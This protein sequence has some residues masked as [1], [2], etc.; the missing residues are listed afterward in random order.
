MSLIYLGGINGSG[1]TTVAQVVS[2][3][4]PNLHIVHGSRELMRQLNLSENDYKTLRSIPEKIKEE[5]FIELLQNLKSKNSNRTIIV[6]AHYVKIL[7]GRITP[8]LGDWYGYF[9]KLILVTG[10]SREIFNRIIVD[11][12]S[13]RRTGRDL[14]GGLEE[15]EDKIEFLQKAQ[16]TSRQV[17]EQVFKEFKI[18][19]FLLLNPDG[20]MDLAVDQLINILERDD[21]DRQHLFL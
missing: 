13:N 15:E 4:L 11:Q 6:T 17:V 9:D 5:A 1:K 10:S 19:Y 16:N 12:I 7:E 21:G 20:K 14:F 2:R 8:S 18:P 3:R